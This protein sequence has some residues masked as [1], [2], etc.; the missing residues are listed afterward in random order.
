MRETTPRPNNRPIILPE[1]GSL[2]N[3]V[4]PFQI[5]GMN[6]RG[7]AIRLGT[8]VHDI[9]TAHEYPQPLAILVGELVVLSGLLGSILKYEGKVTIQAK[10]RDQA[11]VNFLVADFETPGHVR[12][13]A[14]YKAAALAD[15]GLDASFRSLIGAGGYMAMTIDQ[16]ADMERY[17]G[18]VDL[19]GDNLSDCAITY[20]LNSE[21]TPTAL[22]LACGLDPVSGHWRAGGI[23][24]QH[25]AHGEEGGPRLLDRDEQEN[26]R[27]A[28]ILMQSVKSRELLDPQLDLDQL[29]YRLYHEDG[30]RVFEPTD[31]DHRCRC[32]RERLLSVLQSFPA[33]DLADM[34]EEGRITANCQFCN[35]HY[36][37]SPEDIGL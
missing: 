7:R 10:A 25:L 30:V 2:D 35:R 16:G 15:L 29:L 18:I 5:E 31:I 21:Q 36:E 33:S 26:W 32:S 19:D 24:V 22:R 20:F 8:A 17:Q 23:M 37:F 11:A 1:S 9:I 6:V 13:Y 27:R 28:S 34:V 4:K 14:D 3:L 12:G